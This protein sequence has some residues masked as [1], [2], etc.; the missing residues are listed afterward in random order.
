LR[1]VG[2]GI[3][4][5]DDASLSAIRAIRDSCA[6]YCSPIHIEFAR[7]HMSGSTELYVVNEHLADDRSRDRSYDIVVH[8]ILDQL[9]KSTKV[10]W[11]TSG[12]PTIN[13]GVSQGLL[14]ACVDQG[15]T[16]EL[17]SG[18]TAATAVNALLPLSARRDSFLQVNA[19]DLFLTDIAID[20]RLSLFIIQLFQHVSP[21]MLASVR[22]NSA[23]L[24]PLQE[25]LG[26]FYGMDQPCYL[27]RA[28]TSFDAGSV[29]P[30]VLGNLSA[31]STVVEPEMTLVVPAISSSPL[32]YV[33]SLARLWAE[34]DS[35][36]CM[37]PLDTL[38]QLRTRS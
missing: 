8:R 33:D 4:A 19:K 25:R 10:S 26:I 38:A 20:T 15:I 36:K 6:V 16:L 37:S 5:W 32:V 27:V 23:C 13:C 28:A 11:L 1:I 22:L 14:K 24:A 18:V 12:D 30:L 29:I 3:N 9:T 34:N 2:L 31:D 21:R 17:V 35:S 7:A